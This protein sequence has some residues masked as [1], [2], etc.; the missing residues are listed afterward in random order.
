VTV[1]HH[2]GE[3]SLL[4]YATGK[5]GPGAALAL[6]AHV[7][8]CPHCAE[9]VAFLE[10]VGGALM[11]TSDDAPLAQG[12]LDRALAA[13]DGP[14]PAPPPRL[15]PGLP[16]ALRGLK[17]GRWRWAGPG[18]RVAALPDAG[19]DDEYVYLLRA[20]R[21]SRLPHHSHHGVERV[22]VLSGAFMDNGD[23]FGPGDVSERDSSH[24]H[25]PIVSPDAD[26]LCLVATEGRLKL[27]GIARLL[28]PYFGI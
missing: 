7:K 1:S 16:P 3:E 20:K 4:A 14:A 13:L 5:L 11:E 19:G 23:R 26:C 2:P 10:R 12:A 18:V 21:G 8:A 22:T 6:A 28:Q 17:V 9:E 27:S 15:P 25:Q 24:A